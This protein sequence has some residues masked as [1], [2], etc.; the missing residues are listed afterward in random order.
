MRDGNSPLYSPVEFCDV[1]LKLTITSIHWLD[2]F[3][4][5]LVTRTTPPNRPIPNAISNP[6]IIIQQPGV[7]YST[8]SKSPT[9]SLSQS[10][11]K[12]DGFA[13]TGCSKLWV[14]EGPLKLRADW[15]YWQCAFSGS[16]HQWEES[17]CIFANFRDDPFLCGPRCDLC[18]SLVWG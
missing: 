2:S 6:N 3:S 10:V 17:L 11:C 8:L 1:I 7:T 12:I 16:S 13:L 9:S 15:S 5:P 4:E 14:W 18:L